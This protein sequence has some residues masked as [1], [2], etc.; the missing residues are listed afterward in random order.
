MD[1]D[2]LAILIVLAWTILGFVAFVMVLNLRRKVARLTTRF[3][4]SV[5]VLSAELKALRETGVEPQAAP[6]PPAFETQEAHPEPVVTAAP[7]I[8]QALAPAARTE[9]LEQKLAN[10]WMLWAGAVALA[11]GG[12]F[13]VKFA[14]DQ[15]WFGPT[16]RTLMGFLAGCALMAG[17]E[18][19]RRQPPQRAATALGPN[20]V[21][22]ALTA[23]GV[24]IAYTSAYAAFEVYGLLPPLLAFIVLG[25][26]SVGAV[27]LALVQGPLVAVLGIVGG[28][29]TPLLVASENP[30]TWGLYIYLTFI[31]A[32][33]LMVV[34]FTH[35]WWLGLITLA[36]T[37]AWLLLSFLTYGRPQDAEAIGT[38]ML[39][40]AALNLFLPAPGL[41]DR[42][43]PSWNDVLEGRIG[44]SAAMAWL[45]MIMVA[46]F[47]F[48]LLR[49][50]AYGG[51]SLVVLGLFTILC[52]YTGRRAPSFDTLP[53]LAGVLTLAAI[54][55]W[56]L[57]AILPPGA[58]PD[59][60]HPPQPDVFVS[61]Y[62]P[63][64]ILAPSLASFLS[65]TAGFG[66]LFGL[67]GFAILWRAARPAIWAAVAAAFP[68]LMLTVAY[69][70]IEA[71][72]IDFGWAAVAI[73]LAA[74]NVFAASRLRT[75][76]DAMPFTIGVGAFAAAAVAAITLGA[77]MALQEAWLTVAL[78]LQLPALA[79][80][81]NRL[82]LKVLRPV[83]MVIAAAV[84]V[85]L[86]L[87]PELM[88]YHVGGVPVLNWILYG[89]GIPAVAFF[90]AGRWFRRSADDSL[91]AILEAGTLLFATLLVSLELHNVLVGPIAKSGDGLIEP[92]LRTIAWLVMAIGIA[93]NAHLESR[94]IFVWGRNTLA[95]AAV[96][97]I[98]V[99]QV[100]QINPLWSGEAVGTLPILNDLL[101]AYGIPA[102]LI[103]LFTRT[104]LRQPG[105]VQAGWI[106][107]FVLVFIDITLEVRHH[108]QGPVL[109]HWGVSDAEWYAYSAAWLGLSGVLLALGIRA[110]SAALRY[111]SLGVLVLTVGKVFLFDMAAL[112]GLY[113]AGSFVGLGLCLIAVGYLY[114]R[115]VFA[116]P[117]KPADL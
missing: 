69:W 43:V 85:R 102:A 52:F 106:L 86:V 65:T 79:W 19:L 107:G 27:L 111:G 13:L 23:A 11:L 84:L 8:V 40:V 34:R 90:C 95:G 10:R 94:P 12:A 68:V 88:Q 67:G 96:F 6:P 71:F 104:A 56:H 110:Q 50:N 82:G 2:A 30:S 16:A 92:S 37:A 7:P 51:T 45:S 59:P 100:L 66:A 57:P 103:L 117:P 98:V 54:A 83:A 101:L 70:R 74:A 77:A 46:M 29:V 31:I 87:N 76:S 58:L 20:Y 53:V 14:I 33:A 64:P 3:E 73:A 22:P 21:P 32:A 35:A 63:G 4:A 36:G 112:T 18:W 99:I 60:V 24:S 93:R 39:G 78:S 5:Q 17:G 25:V 97:Q 108:F 44:A 62:N 113:R 55:A 47:V 41:L 15:G 89:Y 81:G 105:L 114:Q 49:M 42:P 109:S 9:T 72:G 80:I 38:F 26:L 75:H 116:A 115:F 1:S 91:V 28:F 61:G 48:A